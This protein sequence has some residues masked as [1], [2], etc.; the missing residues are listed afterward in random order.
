MPRCGFRRA[1]HIK[2]TENPNHAH[3][4]KTR[5]C[6]SVTAPWPSAPCPFSSS[7]EGAREE[8]HGDGFADR[9]AKLAPWIRKGV[10]YVRDRVTED[11]MAALLPS[12]SAPV[13][14]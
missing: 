3:I 12:T 2:I 5:S 10:R 13:T 14:S 8:R 4:S 7:T 1:P 9:K 11:N 6:S